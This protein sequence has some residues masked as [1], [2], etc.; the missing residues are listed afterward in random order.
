MLPELGSLPVRVRPVPFETVESFGQ[1]LAAANS[2]PERRWRIGRLAA[3]EAGSRLTLEQLLEELGALR[4]GHFAAQRA[5]L[6]AHEDDSRCG[7]CVT[8][9]DQRFGCTRCTNGATARQMN[10]DGPRVCPRHRRWVG[11]GASPDEQFQVGS[12][13]LAAD[14][15]YRRLR[16]AGVIDAHRFAEILGAVDAW[17]EAETDHLAD[18]SERFIV[19]V[20]I[21]QH[22]LAP[23]ALQKVK[24]RSVVAA[25][26]YQRLSTSIEEIVGAASCTVLTDAVWL[27]VRNIGHDESSRPHC[28]A[29]E[30]AAEHV[31]YN[32]ELAQLCTSFYPRGRHR[33]LVQFV[34]CDLP[35]TRFDLAWTS[36]QQNRYLCVL[37]HRFTA[38]RKSL[39]DARRSD[40]CRYCARRAP[41]RGFNTLADTNPELVAEWHPTLN[42]DLRPD[43]ILSG[44]TRRVV[45]LCSNG[46]SFA[47]PVSKRSRGDGCGYC[48]NRLVDPESNALS[49]THP[50]LAAEWHP[51]RNGRLAADDVVAGSASKRWWR[52]P[53][54]GHDYLMSPVVR[55]RVGCGCPYCARKRVDAA[56]NL[57]CT[58]PQVAALWHPTKNGNLAPEKVVSGSNRRVWFRCD[59]GHEWTQV[60]NQQVSRKGCRDCVV[61]S[62]PKGTSMRDTHPHLAD[63][64]DP[65]LNGLITPDNITGTTKRYVWW[66]CSRQ[67]RWRTA[68]KHRSMGN[69][70]CLVCAN[71]RVV[72]GDNDMATTHPELAKEWHPTK[73]G[74][75]VP[76]R[77][78]AG[79]S[80]RIWWQCADHGHE[81][82]ASGN[83]RIR[84][85]RCPACM[86][87]RVV[88]VNDLATTHPCIAVEWDHTANG[89]TAP[90]DVQATSQKARWWRCAQGHERLEAPR[91]RITRGGCSDCNRNEGDTP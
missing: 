47:K 56:N 13:V 17:V 64:L 39:V 58:H 11:P 52:C 85:H 1:R 45:W 70:G 87:V 88:G 4:S 91:R 12:E 8:G 23:H 59:A 74:T 84:G 41:L 25:A 75:L 57:A 37:G 22:V 49:V 33:H 73:N 82:L 61:R 67:H 54:S 28:F 16:M 3:H 31:D 30:S 42:Q 9:L 72:S 53:A 19:A 89:R 40:G 2:I 55:S 32:D 15:L 80:K 26:R 63:E 44:S 60:V 66:R 83:V 27:L 7:E 62:V 65:E 78:V 81:W 29:G 69:G 6:P 10:H 68:P 5:A 48:A 77:I 90:S 43:E 18:P 14:R 35:R 71:R 76:E 86:K 50:E 20:R 21:A 34:S 38:N 24:D 79:T 51:S 46:H 36:N